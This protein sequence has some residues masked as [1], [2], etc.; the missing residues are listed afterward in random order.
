MVKPGVA[1]SASR[2]SYHATAS[3]DAA[4]PSAPAT[5]MDAS[6]HIAA[7]DMTDV[8]SANAA[9]PAPVAVISPSMVRLD[10]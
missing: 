1:Q 3:P 2:T 7:P 10:G 4:A 5:C 9:L 6:S 8:G